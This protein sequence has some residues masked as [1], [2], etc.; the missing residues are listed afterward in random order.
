MERLKFK[1]FCIGVIILLFMSGCNSSIPPQIS[2]A[3]EGSPAL[4]Q[5]ISDPENY[6]S[7]AV[8]WG[9]VITKTENRD[10]TT[11][12]TIVSFPLKNDGRPQ[13]SAQSTGR[14][15]A[16]FDEFLEPM[17]YN[18]DRQITVKGEYFQME[19]QNVGDFPYPYPLVKVDSYFLW[20]KLIEPV[21]YDYPPFGWR[22]D[23][24]Y[25]PYYYHPKKLIPYHE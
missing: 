10:K 5:V 8:R 12:L 16:V 20:P 4:Q 11:R 17:V 13:L 3:V 22:Y 2:Q 7:A 25:Y 21:E 6:I 9:G 1:N 19:T 14:F 23:P 24:W 15:I 18:Q